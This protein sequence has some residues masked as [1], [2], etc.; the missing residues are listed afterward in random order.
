[1]NIYY[2]QKVEDYSEKEIVFIART[3]KTAKATAVEIIK[4]AVGIHEDDVKFSGD[5]AGMSCIYGITSDSD[6]PILKISKYQLIN[7]SRYVYL[8]RYGDYHRYCIAEKRCLF[9]EMHT[10]NN[11][12]H[13]KRM[14]VLK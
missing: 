4:D 11:L 13:I 3:K 8:I 2:I 1:M 9:P 10:Q 12:I 7:P 5:Y 6:E 14:E